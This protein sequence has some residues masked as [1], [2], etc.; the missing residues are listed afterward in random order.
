MPKNKVKKN[1]KEKKKNKK[2][3][4]VESSLK[5]N[6]HPTISRRA[7][8]SGGSGASYEG[9]IGEEK[10]KLIKSKQKGKLTQAGRSEEDPPPP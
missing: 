3:G 2:K 7:R 6:G 4:T 1:K 10:T 9:S 8:V 5:K